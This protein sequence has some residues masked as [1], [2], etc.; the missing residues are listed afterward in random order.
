MRNVFFSF[1][2]ANDIF[3][4]NVVR[5]SWVG[6]GGPEPAGF[7][8][9]SMWESAR[10]RDKARLESMIDGALR[11]TSVTAVLIG[12]ETASRFW[13]KHEII[14]SWEHGKGLLGVRIHGIRDKRTKMRSRR[15][16]SPFKDLWVVDA[17]GY[18]VEL[19]DIV[20]TYDWVRDD[21]YANFADWVEEA[22]FDAGR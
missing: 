18:D 4:A 6:K 8:D 13:V 7:R 20:P 5:N 9:R 10:T 14:A 3:R 11:G 15:G 1:Y 21:G 19:E 16:P 12:A 22:A 2:Y 17:D